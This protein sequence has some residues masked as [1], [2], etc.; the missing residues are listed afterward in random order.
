MAAEDGSLLTGFRRQHISEGAA[1]ESSRFLFRIFLFLKQMK[2]E[3]A[4]LNSKRRLC[5]AFETFSAYLYK[6]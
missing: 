4:T 2:I 5:K 3:G 1:H 6:I